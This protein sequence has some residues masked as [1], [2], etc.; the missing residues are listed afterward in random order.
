MCTLTGI[1]LCL[2]FLSL[3][4][5]NRN[6][7]ASQQSLT[8]P[9][10]WHETQPQHLVVPLHSNTNWIAP[11]MMH[12]SSNI[13]QR[14]EIA[15]I[16]WTKFNNQVIYA[17]ALQQIT[18]VHSEIPSAL[19]VKVHRTFFRP[20]KPASYQ[21]TFNRSLYETKYLMTSIKACTT[22]MTQCPTRVQWATQIFDELPVP[23]LWPLNAG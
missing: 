9:H 20:R 19:K 14:S 23:S 6:Y 8:W 11:R 5:L 21:R 1:S 15:R 22:G 10:A 12:H 7:I 13:L 2:C 4:S 18:A 16:Y 17:Q 3:Y